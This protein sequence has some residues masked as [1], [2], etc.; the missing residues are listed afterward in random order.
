M[1]ETKEDFEA[2]SSRKN[3]NKN[4]INNGHVKRKEKLVTKRRGDG[5]FVKVACV[6]SKLLFSW[7][8]YRE[9]SHLRPRLTIPED[10]QRGDNLRPSHRSER[11]D[12]IHPYFPHSHD[13]GS[14]T[15]E[16][17]FLK[18]FQTFS[19]HWRVTSR[20]ETC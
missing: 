8:F 1:D 17:N 2:S 16:P 19:S 3:K 15:S 6:R 7:P 20:N 4:L 13:R 11:V 5:I 9:K 12:Q 18:I 10:E 14:Q